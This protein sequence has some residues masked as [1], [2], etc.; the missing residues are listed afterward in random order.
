V[1]DVVFFSGMPDEVPSVID[2][3]L[4]AG[5]GKEVPIEGTIDI[6][7]QPGNGWIDLYPVDLTVSVD[8]GGQDVLPTSDTD[9]QDFS[10]LSDLIIE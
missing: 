6:G 7:I 5:L 2:E 3:H 1:D 9:N 10:V 4:Y 8:M